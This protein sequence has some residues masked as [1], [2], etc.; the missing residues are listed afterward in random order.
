M[1]SLP[2]ILFLLLLTACGKSGEHASHDH[3]EGAM[4]G[5][6]P[7]QALYNQVM[8]VHDEVMPKMEDIYKLKKELM[9]QIANTP[10]MVVERKQQLEKIISKTGYT[11]LIIWSHS[12]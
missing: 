5:D 12:V 9:E 6:S 1:K 2:K 3:E 4:D 7:N 8:G 10:D 11:K